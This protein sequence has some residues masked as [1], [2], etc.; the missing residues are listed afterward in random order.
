MIG[1][2]HSINVSPGGVPKRAIPE[3]WI[4]VLGV[5]DDRQGDS[6]IHGGPDRAVCL[7]ALELIKALRDE[8]HPIDVGST[9]ENLT[10]SG[11]DWSR[12]GPGIR[13]RIGGSEIEIAD[14]THPCKTIAASFTG[15]HFRRISQKLHPGWSR[16]YARVV[17]PG[18]VAVGDTVEALASN[19]VAVADRVAVPSRENN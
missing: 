19:P 12:L 6:R 9:G 14:F 18:H 5:G 4:D 3:A 8:G 1:R 7:Y 2:V 17:T 15:G 10:I 11:L 16:L 13:L